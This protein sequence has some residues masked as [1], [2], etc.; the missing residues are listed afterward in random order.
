MHFG[1]YSDTDEMPPSDRL[2][3]GRMLL[4]PHPGVRSGVFVLRLFQ[5][6]MFSDGHM[7]GLQEL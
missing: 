7:H 4:A 6:E 2:G 1:C 5:R 3:V